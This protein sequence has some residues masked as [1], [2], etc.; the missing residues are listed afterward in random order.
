MDLPVRGGLRSKG[1]GH[2]CVLDAS[3]TRREAPETPTIVANAWSHE[4]ATYHLVSTGTYS[5]WSEIVPAPPDASISVVVVGAGRVATAVAE[6]LRRRGHAIAG[7]SSRTESSADRA[8]ALLRAG[9]FRLG[10]G[11]VPD[12]DLFIVGTADAAIA[13]VT[14]RLA[15]SLRP[16]SVVVH[17]SGA[18]GTAPL[19]AARARGAL[20]AALHPVQACP[21]VATAIRR[22]P[23]SAWGVTCDDDVR[24]WAKRLVEDHLAGSAVDVR[25]PDRVLW[26]AASVMTS[27]GIAALLSAGESV[28]A[29]AGVS[30]A[31]EV[32]APL[33]AGTVANAREGGGGGATLTGPVVRGEGEVVRR[34]LDALRA[35]DEGLAKDYS[36]IAGLIVAAARR[37]GRL[38]S[39]V[40]EAVTSAVE[41][42]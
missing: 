42:S 34:H 2:R 30:A 15:P 38:D 19:G 12:A 13:S 4:G 24:P 8:A 11:A 31:H 22:L 9:T 14:E 3:P 28:L 27:N 29:T 5:D 35:V 26:H 25:E 37:T 40:E 36:A 21:D 23:G 39:A 32:L 7:V 16:G 10:D 20:V 33:A 6:L 17:L 18:S 41:R 1:T